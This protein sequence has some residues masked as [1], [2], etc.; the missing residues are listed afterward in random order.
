MNPRNLVEKIL[1]EIK[2]KSRGSVLNFCKGNNKTQKDILPFVTKYK[3]SVSNLK[4][5]LL[6]KWH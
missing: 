4:D 6:K 3:P 2:F 1:S 5:A